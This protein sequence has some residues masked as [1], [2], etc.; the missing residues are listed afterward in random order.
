[1][2]RKFREWK[3][4]RKEFL[5]VLTEIEGK[6]KSK[7]MMI[8]NKTGK[9][10][11]VNTRRVQ[12]YLDNG[13]LPR[14]KMIKG[15]YLYNYDHIVR[16]LAAISLKNEG[17]SMI[18]IDKIL[19]SH[20]L[21]EITDIYLD[22]THSK[23]LNSISNKQNLKTKYSNAENSEKLKKLGRQEG[24]VLRSQWIKFAVTKWCHLDIRKKELRNLDENQLQTLS[25]V[26]TNTLLSLKAKDIDKLI[27]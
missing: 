18:Q 10:V 20:E 5:N 8:S 23:N 22:V 1:M 19:S 14:A 13:I 4:S 15:E 6:N 27:K 24:R 26:I 2:F 12:Q 21:E 9:R 17:H 11:P 25:E 7:Y 3:G 16:Y